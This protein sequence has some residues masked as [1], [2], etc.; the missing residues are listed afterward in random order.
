MGDVSQ[1][2]G[3][4]LSTIHAVGRLTAEFRWTRS[5]YVVTIAK[6]G[7]LGIAGREEVCPSANCS[8]PLFSWLP[9]FSECVA[10]FGGQIH[11]MDLQSI[12]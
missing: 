2:R 4:I 1:L 5:F 12:C 11:S 10:I 3:L 7:G 8:P 9:H 6:L